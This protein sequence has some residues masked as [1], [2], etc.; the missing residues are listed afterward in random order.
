MSEAIGK[1]GEPF[2]RKLI[3]GNWKMNG[4]K[5]DLQTFEKILTGVEAGND[6][7][8]PLI[9]PP[10]TMIMSMTALSADSSGQVKVGGQ[11]CHTGV[12]GAHTGDISADMLA[13]AGASYVIVGHSER[14]TDHNETNSLIA[15]KADAA[16]KAGLVAII[17]IGESLE[18]R[19]TGATE[20]FVLEQ[21]A[22]SIPADCKTESV[23][24]AYE[25]I[26]AIGT[27]LTASTEQIAE[28]HGA[29]RKALIK[30]F[31][32]EGATV[33][34]LYGGSMKP[35]NA[36]SILAVENVNGGLIGGASLNAEDFLSIYRSAL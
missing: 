34:I 14:R 27:G 16:I 36:A 3:A 1:T 35:G 29:I 15:Q 9:C 4:L 11:D 12:T 10:V 33:P 26:W 31:G 19:N 20:E 23:V 28:V 7:A 2:M 18:I 6:A 8:L 13:N 17:C 30:R 21:L 32:E 5:A 22:A 24:I 25:P